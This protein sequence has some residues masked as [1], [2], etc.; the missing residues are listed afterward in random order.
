MK[1]EKEASTV[2]ASMGSTDVKSIVMSSICTNQVEQEFAQVQRSDGVE[3]RVSVTSSIQQ[4]QG[5]GRAVAREHEE[6]STP[7]G[8]VVKDLD[9]LEMIVQVCQFLAGWAG[10][11]LAQRAG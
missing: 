9:K 4:I 5:G 2:G 11:A 10:D 8:K 3:P 7:E 1:E 6:G